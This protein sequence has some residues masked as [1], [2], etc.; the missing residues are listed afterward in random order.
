MN[1][2]ENNLPFKLMAIFILAVF[3]AI[4][5]GKMIIQKK[6]G[7]TTHQ[8]GKRKEKKLHTVETLMSVATFSVVIIQLLSI[9]FDWNIMPSGARFTGFC[10]AGIGD[11]FFLISVTYMKDSWR[12]G[13]PEKD[14]TK[15]VTDG[16]YKFSRNP[17][18]VGFDFM[19]IGILLMFFN[20]GTLLFSLFSIVMLH[21]QILQE[22]KYM[23][24]T[25]GEEYLEY[26][27]K[28]F[29]YIGRR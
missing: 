10:I 29:R 4:Y 25:F 20:I 11:I 13:I 6:K 1:F 3:Y 24:K 23:A 12:A 21:L 5:F 17:A 19:Y 15:L 14:K 2:S 8:I 7:I 22:E 16:I 28:V 26:K 27:K 9:F 18:F